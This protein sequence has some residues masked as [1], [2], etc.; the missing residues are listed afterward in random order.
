MPCDPGEDHQHF[1]GMYHLQFQDLRV[2]QENNQQE[3]GRKC[4]ELCIE[5]VVQVW[6]CKGLQREPTGAEGKVMSVG[7]EKCCICKGKRWAKLRLKNR[8]W[9]IKT[10]SGRRADERKKLL[11]KEQQGKLRHMGLLKGP[12]NS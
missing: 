3:T 1:G 10:G 2:I 8:K 4:S 11:L 5:N 7:M 9:G 6:A 12:P